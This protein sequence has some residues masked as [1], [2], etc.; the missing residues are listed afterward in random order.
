MG[1][2]MLTNF[3][4]YSIYSIASSIVQ[5]NLSTVNDVAACLSNGSC[6]IVILMGMSAKVSSSSPPA[7]L[8]VQAW[9]TVAV[10]IVWILQLVHTRR[11]FD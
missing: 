8:I 5:Q 6:S 3:V 7:T 2:L 11:R 4:I 9:L 10:V 1:Y